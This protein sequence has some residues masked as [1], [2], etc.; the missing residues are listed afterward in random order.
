M[1]NKT[2]FV[3]YTVNVFKIIFRFKK[4]KKE[5]KRSKKKPTLL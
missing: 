5:K 3:D 2:I 4:N 1:H